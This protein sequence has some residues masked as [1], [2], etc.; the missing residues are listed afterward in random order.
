MTEIRPTTGPSL[1]TTLFAASAPP[2]V[3]D[4][5][6]RKE[7]RSGLI[8]LGAFATLFIGWS[9]LT[10]LD[11]AATAGGQISVSGHNQTVQHREG[12]VVASVDVVEGQHVAANQVLVELAPEEVGAEV[13]SLRSQEISLQAQI[14]R[15]NSEIQGAGRIEWPASFAAMTGQDLTDAKEAMRNQQAQFDAGLGAL[16]SQQG[17]AGRK[18]AGL[19]EQVTGSQSQLDAVMRQQVLIDQQLKGVRSLAEKGYASQ[20]QIRALERTA[21]DLAGSRGQFAANIADYRQQIAESQLQ[22]SALA[23][24][25]SETAAQALRESQDQLNTLQP[26]LEAARGQLARGTLRA[27]TDGIV[28]GLSVFAPGSVVAPGQK[29][30]EIVPSRPVLVVQAKIASNQIEGVHVG[31][32]SQV[33]FNSQG[34]RG[35]PILNG[36]LTKLSADSFTDEKTGQSFFTGEVTVPKSQLDMVRQ[37]RGADSELRPGVQVQVTIPLRKRTAFEYLFD[38]LT[39]ALWTSFRQR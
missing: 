25:R 32:K 1:P 4:D 16:R 38:P 11:A 20:N 39:Q 36:T 5:D 13:K 29:L 23:R 35:I 28:T 7:I 17:M 18:A 21:A 10:P 8:V 34:S 37:S 9:T 31:Q 22:S 14:A 26:K 33:R 3:L 6:P 2:A 27:Q 12:G 30:M 15:L 19:S 24:Q